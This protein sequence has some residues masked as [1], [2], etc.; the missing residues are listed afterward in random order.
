M[1]RDVEEREDMRRAVPAGGRKGTGPQKMPQQAQAGQSE[2]RW[3]PVVWIIEQQW[4]Q[5][6]GRPTV[7]LSNP[8]ELTLP[9]LEAKRSDSL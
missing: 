1:T 5:K 7:S 2:L 8:P 3:L 9:A 4:G 6:S